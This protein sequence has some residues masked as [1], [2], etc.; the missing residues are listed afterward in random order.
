MNTFASSIESFTRD[1][2]C[3]FLQVAS[4]KMPET[5][6]ELKALSPRVRRKW[7]DTL[8]RCKGFQIHWKKTLLFASVFVAAAVVVLE[9][10]TTLRYTTLITLH[11]DTPLHFTTLQLRITLRYATLH[12]YTAF[13]YT[14]LHYT[15]L[16]YTQYTP[17]HYTPFPFTTLHKIPLQY[18]TTTTTTTATS[19]LPYTAFS[20]NTLHHTTLQYAT[21]HS[22]TLRYTTLHSTN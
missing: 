14:T 10:H 3:H 11:L 7:R 15:A 18:T 2:H 17:Q 8:E 20:F 12:H 22:T 4:P 21:V 19:K 16:H 9:W 1:F 13:H 6:K 5:V